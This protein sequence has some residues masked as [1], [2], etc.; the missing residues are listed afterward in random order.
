MDRFVLFVGRRDG[1]PGWWS[2]RQ[3]ADAG[4]VAFDGPANTARTVGPLRVLRSSDPAWLREEM[5]RYPH[6]RFVIVGDLR[7]LRGLGPNV[8]GVFRP[9]RRLSHRWRW[10]WEGSTARSVPVFRGDVSLYVV[11]TER[12]THWFARVGQVGGGQLRI[13]REAYWDD[14]VPGVM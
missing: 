7:D 12:P 1:S 2:R 13:A 3:A 10:W 5:R 11:R 9:G 14:D 8:L 6:L 4:E